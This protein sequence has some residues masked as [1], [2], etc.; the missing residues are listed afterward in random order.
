[1][2]LYLKFLIMFEQWH[3]LKM[4]DVYEFLEKVCFLR[5]RDYKVG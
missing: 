1:M 3:H 4:D 5:Q 2:L